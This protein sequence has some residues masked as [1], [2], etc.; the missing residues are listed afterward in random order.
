MLI[1]N[2]F[3]SSLLHVCRH[4]LP[5]W[6]RRRGKVNPTF[7][8]RWIIHLRCSSK[9]Q[10]SQCLETFLFCGSTSR[11][12][13]IIEW[14]RYLITINRSISADYFS[15]CPINFKRADG[16]TGLIDSVTVVGNAVIDFYKRS[17]NELARFLTNLFIFLQRMNVLNQLCQ[18]IPV[19]S[20]CNLLQLKKKDVKLRKSS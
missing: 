9:Q 10:F 13:I 1:V 7:Y 17:Q 20:V 5:L 11:D 3:N 8:I 12:G 6:E 4:L 15:K 14:C 16:G 19:R 2:L 18:Q